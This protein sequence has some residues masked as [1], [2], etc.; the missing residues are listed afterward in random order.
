MAQSG[1]RAGQV[2]MKTHLLL[3][4]TLGVVQM[5]CLAA[6]ERIDGHALALSQP[7]DGGSLFPACDVSEPTT[8]AGQ[9]CVANTG[10]D[11]RPQWCDGVLMPTYRCQCVSGSVECIAYDCNPYGH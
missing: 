7:S 4:L 3:W 2:S 8:L 10:C 1:R 11:I 6:A 5:S 9:A